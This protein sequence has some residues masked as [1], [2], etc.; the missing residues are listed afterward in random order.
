M[1]MREEMKDARACTLASL[2]EIAEVKQAKLRGGDRLREDLGMD[3]LSSLELLSLVSERLRIDIEVEEAMEIRTV[4]DACAF[5][6]R[7]YRA[8]HGDGHAS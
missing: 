3:S 7:Y 6:E 2:A 5:V 8:K 4:D 1:S